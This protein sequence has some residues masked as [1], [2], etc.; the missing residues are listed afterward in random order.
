MQ[1]L[2]DWVEEGSAA[3]KIGLHTHQNPCTGLTVATDK[4]TDTVVSVVQTFTC[5]EIL[6][7]INSFNKDR[8]Y[9]CITE[10]IP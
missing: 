10:V 3:F 6:E 5:L 9:K 4:D 8:G 2:K 1:I 7:I